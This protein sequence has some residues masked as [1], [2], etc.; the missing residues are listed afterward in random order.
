MSDCVEER[1]VRRS[2]VYYRGGAYYHPDLPDG[3]RVQLIIDDRDASRVSVFRRRRFICVAALC[4][5]SEE[6]G[7]GAT[8]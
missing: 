1:V 5:G 2:V 6:T 7:K 3:E 8:S 4:Q